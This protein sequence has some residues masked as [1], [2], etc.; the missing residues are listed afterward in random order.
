MAAQCSATAV[1][2]QSMTDSAHREPAGVDALVI[3]GRAR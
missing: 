3:I 1:D 2:S